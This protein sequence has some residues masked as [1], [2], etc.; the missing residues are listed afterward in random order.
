MWVRAEDAIEPVVCAEDFFVARGIFAERTRRVSSEDMI[1]HLRRLGESVATVSAGAIDADEAMPSGA[2]YRSRFDSL[3]S[4]YRLAGIEPTRDYGYVEVSRSLRAPHSSLVEDLTRRLADFGAAVAHDEATDRLLINGEYTA[5]V[6]LS[7]CRRTGAG[8]LRW[9]G[10]TDQ[11]VI[12]DVT[13]LVRMDAGNSGPCPGPP[14]V[15]T[16][17]YSR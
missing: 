13:V 12:P 8:S 10:N 9:V 5:S 14:A 1:A 17:G 15:P 7:R 6:V 2:A 11:R 4:A 3:L 16:T